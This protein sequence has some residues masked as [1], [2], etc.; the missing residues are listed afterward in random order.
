MPFVWSDVL[1]PKGGIYGTN[2]DIGVRE[3]GKGSS[4]VRSRRDKFKFR[5]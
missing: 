1:E 5:A 3:E 2:A 4:K